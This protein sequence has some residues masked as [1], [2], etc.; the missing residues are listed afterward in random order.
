MGKFFKWAQ[1]AVPAALIA[2]S[3]IAAL[4]AR[5]DVVQLG[6][7]L[8]SSGSIG[9]GNWNT[10]VSGLSSAI[11]SLIPITG[12]TQ[13]EI[14][15][16]TFSTSAA[17]SVNSVLITDATTRS[18]VAAAIAGIGYQNGSTNYSAAF[19]LMRT[20]LTT[21][22]G[23]TTAGATASYVNFATDGDP[24][25]DTTNTLPT[26]NA[27]IAAGVDNISIEGIGVTASTATFLKNSICYPQ[28]CDD[29]NPYNFPSQGFYIGVADAA[30]Y[31]AAIS[32]KI[33]VVTNQ[34]PE[35]ASLALVSLA[36][37]G[38]GVSRRFAKA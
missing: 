8:D 29:T 35:P 22:A 38:L 25:V 28:P 30:A 15:V 23:V 37:L 16:V 10:I 1:R 27:L 7:I 3:S 5:A 12:T 6:F 19:D 20:T 34:V 17:L 2:V 4:P 9:S 24:N 11:G 26:R 18:N 13:Y 33:R 31:V 32:H 14:S 21:G 36:L